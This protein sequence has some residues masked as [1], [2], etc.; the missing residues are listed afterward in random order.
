M[1]HA[2]EDAQEQAPA[3]ATPPAPPTCD[4]EKHR[5]F[6]FWIGEWSVTVNGQQAG[7]NVIQRVYGNCALQENWSSVSPFTGGSFNIY[8]RATDQWHQTWVDSTGTLLQLDGGIKDGKMVLS[9]Q[10]PGPDGSMTTNRITWTPNDDGSVRQLWETSTDG[11]TWTT[12]FDGLYVRV[13]A[14]E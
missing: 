4:S 11:E 10:R 6:D 7:H 12:A 9:G 1:V 13:D 14:A 3:P 5:Q 8:D 2:Q